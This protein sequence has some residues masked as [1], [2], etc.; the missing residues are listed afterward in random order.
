MVTPHSTC[1]YFVICI[2]I[3]RIV[4]DIMVGCVLLRGP[5]SARVT[6]VE[7]PNTRLVVNTPL[8]PV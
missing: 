3:D 6:V 5:T 4:F 8:R 1:V 2:V 7:F